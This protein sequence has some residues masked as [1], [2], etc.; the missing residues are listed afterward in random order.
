M[1][2]ASSLTRGLISLEMAILEQKVQAAG[3]LFLYA[4]FFYTTQFLGPLASCNVP[5]SCRIQ[6]IA[7]S[8]G[9]GR[10]SLLPIMR[11]DHAIW[12]ASPASTDSELQRSVNSELNRRSR[13]S[14]ELTWD[15]EYCRRYSSLCPCLFARA[16][17]T[18]QARVG[19]RAGL[20]YPPP[21]LR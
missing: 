2:V 9:P 3:F 8:Q 7:L 13:I 5:I 11:W 21:L 20:A 12:D 18:Q 14:Q 15:L 19:V 4:S 10:R 1:S 16:N 6:C 17:L